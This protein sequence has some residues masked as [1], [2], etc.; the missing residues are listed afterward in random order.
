MLEVIEKADKKSVGSGVPDRQVSKFRDQ[1]Q[2]QDN[3]R[4]HR[5]DRRQNK[6]NFRMKE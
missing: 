1:I 2:G 3:D 4:I 6:T 5:P